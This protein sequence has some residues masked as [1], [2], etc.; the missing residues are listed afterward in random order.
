M[1]SWCVHQDDLRIGEVQNACDFI[2]GGLRASGRHR[3]LLHQ[4][5]V[6]QCGLAHIG[7]ANYTGIARLE[8]ICHNYL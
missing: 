8:S 3:N 7:S 5:T 2:A 4:Q 6:Q 1:N